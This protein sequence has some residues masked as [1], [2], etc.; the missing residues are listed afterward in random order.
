VSASSA[1]KGGRVLRALLRDGWAIKRQLGSHRVLA[2]EGRSDFVFP[3]HDE[4]EIGPRALA[5]IAQHTGLQPTTSDPTPSA[6]DDTP[7][8]G[9]LR[10]ILGGFMKRS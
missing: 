10:N 2:Q 6:A 7:G 5:R 4:E 9:R 8:T 3:F 1:A